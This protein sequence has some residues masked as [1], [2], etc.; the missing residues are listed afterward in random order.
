LKDATRSWKVALFLPLLTLPQVIVAGW[1]IN[2]LA[3]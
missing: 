3:T 2:T 1:L